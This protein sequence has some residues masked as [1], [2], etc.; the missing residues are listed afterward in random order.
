MQL[1]SMCLPCGGDVLGTWQ[2]SSSCLVVSDTLDLSPVGAPGCSAP[3][4]GS[5]SVIGT[6][7]ANADGTYSDNT[8]TTGEEHFTLSP[9]LLVIS[10]TAVTC[11]GH[12]GSIKTGARLRLGDLHPCGP[13]D[14]RARLPPSISQAVSGWSRSRLRRATTT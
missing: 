13:A 12:R 14:A 3:V 9:S 11:E 10:S 4:T 7:T 1:A 2:V 6:F 8:V 5:L